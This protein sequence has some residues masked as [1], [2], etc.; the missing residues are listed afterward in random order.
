MYSDRSSTWLNNAPKTPGSQELHSIDIKIIVVRCVL[1]FYSQNT[2]TLVY[3]KKFGET[4]SEE[5]L[6]IVEKILLHYLKNST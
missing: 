4:S 2:T 6:G 1:L 5:L 3:E